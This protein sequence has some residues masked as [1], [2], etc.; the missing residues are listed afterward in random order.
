MMEDVPKET[1]QTKYKDTIHGGIQAKLNSLK[2][3]S[4]FEA[5]SYAHDAEKEINSITRMIQGNQPHPQP[6]HFNN[7]PPHFNNNNKYNANS[8]N[9][10]RTRNFTP[11]RNFNAPRNT[12]LP[13]T[14]FNPNR[15]NHVQAPFNRNPPPQNTR[16]T[17]TYITL[18]W[19]AIA[20]TA[21]AT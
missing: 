11:P 19:Y 17:H 12:P 4:L 21:M 18:A 7:R 20:V 8:Y 15:P 3:T 2:P 6:N 5:I 10:P 9:T 14:N 1:L 13:R 16:T